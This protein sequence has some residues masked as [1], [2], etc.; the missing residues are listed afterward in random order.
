ML[1]RQ[2]AIL[3]SRDSRGV[4]S[5]EPPIDHTGS[6]E[7]TDSHSVL[8]SLVWFIDSMLDGVDDGRVEWY[9]GKWIANRQTWL[10]ATKKWSCESTARD[11][12]ARKRARG[13]E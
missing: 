7:T 13:E 6:C 2:T 8:E 1:G 9:K 3:W 12:A 4:R 10:E 11:K 5:A